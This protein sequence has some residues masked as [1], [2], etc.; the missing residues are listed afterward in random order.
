MQNM[1]NLISDNYDKLNNIISFGFDKIIKKRSID[2]LRFKK[3]A[4]VLDLCT[5]TGDIPDIIRKKH[6]QVEITGIDISEK[7]LKIA[8]IKNPDIN[9]IQGDCTNLPIGDNSFDTMTICYG[10]RN[11]KR[12]NEAIKEFYRVLKP[13]GEILHLDFGDKN[14]VSKIF[15]TVLNLIIK[16]P[17]IKD[18]AKFAY[19]YLIESKQ[20]FPPPDEIIKQFT[21]AGFELKQK[22]FFLFRVICVEIFKK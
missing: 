5:G 1:F 12:K 10:L 19:K 11:I 20:K 14:F 3:C 2:L 7:M 8:K 18:D 22:R 17:L 6:P 16:T 15:D 21:E 13:E 4:K 9:F